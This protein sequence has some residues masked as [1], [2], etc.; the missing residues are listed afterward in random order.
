MDLAI[1]GMGFSTKDTEK[2]ADERWS[3]VEIGEKLR[4][5]VPGIAVID[6]DFSLKTKEYELGMGGK[7][8]GRMPEES[9]KLLEDLKASGWQILVVSN[10]PKEGHQVASC[11]KTQEW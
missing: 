7:E 10:Q 11:Q 9:I 8:P 5:Q 2:T 3:M 1:E 6:N 4:A